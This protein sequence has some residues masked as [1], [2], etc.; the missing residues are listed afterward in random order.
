MVSL[1]TTIPIAQSYTK[2]CDISD[3]PTY[4]DGFDRAL[5]SILAKALV[6]PSPT[7]SYFTPEDCAAQAANIAHATY[8]P[9]SSI[10]GHRAGN[11][12]QNSENAVFIG[13]QLSSKAFFTSAATSAASSSSISSTTCSSLRNTCAPASISPVCKSIFAKIAAA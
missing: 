2:Y 3:R 13:C 12:Y 9:I 5:A 4:S 7:D 10:W 8:L 1:T 11:P 6:V